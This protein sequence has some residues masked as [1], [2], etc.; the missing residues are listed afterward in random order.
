LHF[1]LSLFSILKVITSLWQA[2]FLCALSSQSRL[3]FTSCQMLNSGTNSGLKKN[4]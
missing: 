1:R 3:L 2:L 4:A